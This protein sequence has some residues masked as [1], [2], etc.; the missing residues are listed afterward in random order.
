MEQLKPQLP[1]HQ[2]RLIKELLDKKAR[3]EKDAVFTF[4]KLQKKPIKHI[5]IYKKLVKHFTSSNKHRS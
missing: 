3:S 4:I 5:S 2:R 1:L